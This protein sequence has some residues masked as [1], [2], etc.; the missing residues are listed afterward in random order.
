MGT[1]T[2]W[3]SALLASLVALKGTSA[4][5]VSDKLKAAGCALGDVTKKFSRKVKRGKLIK[6]KTTAATELPAG[7]AVDAVFSKGK[8]KK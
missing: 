8:P 5:S 7:S 4:S 2:R 6:L 1:G 3:A